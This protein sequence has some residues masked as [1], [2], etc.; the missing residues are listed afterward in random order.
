M[1]GREIERERELA[2][3]LYHA[4]DIKRQ[5]QRQDRDRDRTETDTETET[6]FHELIVGS[7][8]NC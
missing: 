7:F 3:L 6:P 1:T 5:R 4:I 2:T 8:Q